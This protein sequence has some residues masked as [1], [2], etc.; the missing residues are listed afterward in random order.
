MNKNLALIGAGYWGQNLAR[1]FNKL[2]VL[3]TIC[4]SSPQILQKYNTGYDTVQK[5][6]SLDDVFKNAEITCVAIAAPA[7]LHYELAKL[8]LDHGKD[9]FVEK[10]LSLNVSQGEELIAL[11]KKKR[12]ILMVGHLLQYHPC[13]EKLKQ[14]I[15]NGELGRL[16]YITSNRLNLGKIRK[17]ENALWSFA[18]HDISVILALAG[19]QM[20]EKVNCFGESYLTRGIADTTLT[21]LKFPNNLCSHI[22]VSW[23]NPF[24]EQKLTVIGSEGMVV[25]D[26]TQPWQR[27]LVLYRGYLKWDNGLTPVPIKGDGEPIQVPEEEPLLR[28]CN[29][30]I[31]CCE[32]RSN[33][34]TDG[35]EALKVLKILQLAQNSLELA[36]GEPAKPKESVPAQ[37][38]Y[39]VHPSAIVDDG[40]IIGKGTKI[41]HFSH[42]MPG[43]VIGEKCVLGQNVNVDSGTKIGNNVKIQ[44]NVSVYTGIEIEDDV[45]L[46]PSCV[47]TNV[48]NPRSQVNRHSLYERTVI[49]RG[50]TIGANATI[51]CGVT[52]GQYAFIGAGAVVTKDVP[53]YALMVGNPAKQVGWMSRHGHKLKPGPDGIMV[54]PES[55]FRY[56][57]VSPGVLRCLDYPEDKPLPPELSKGAKSY[58]EFKQQK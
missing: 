15:K 14:L 5:T 56:K 26:D 50:A 57:E 16:Y 24:K 44:N 58:D 53:D 28:E 30:F 46:G 22:Y 13:I 42:I 19:G 7:V 54:C 27:K 9:V 20:P 41:W 36:M 12:H 38:E 25:F 1:N 35:Q 31:Q 48:T 4:D 34:I 23:L 39:F 45:F 11:A 18:P 55:G 3:H 40:A 43:A 2:G 6:T 8:A 52:I 21:I 47:L 37:K 29:H 17:E 32:N 49:K 33:P 10:P 51:V